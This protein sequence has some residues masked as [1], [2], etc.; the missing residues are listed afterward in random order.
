MKR[1]T[2]YSGPLLVLAGVLMV[3]GCIISA[4]FVVDVTLTD[5][6]FNA[7]DNYYHTE[8]DLTQEEVW[9]K[10]SDKLDTIETVGFEMYIT[11]TGEATSTFSAYVD[12]ID[13]PVQTSVA[14]IETNTTQILD[15]LTIASGTTRHITYGE[16]F[17]YLVEADTLKA[18]A[19]EGE[20]HFYVTRTAA[21]GIFIDT[22]RV[23]VTLAAS[24]T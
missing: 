5:E 20:F 22:V 19:M 6:D 18:Y 11:N 9:Q 14:L 7:G 2:A 1:I 8:V 10:H 12:P 13:D 24:D 4:T 17:S 16:S 3:A 23:I 15:G 21:A